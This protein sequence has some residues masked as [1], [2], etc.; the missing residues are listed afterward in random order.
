M[1][2][3]IISSKEREAL[4][5][6]FKGVD[7]FIEAHNN[8]SLEEMTTNTHTATQVERVHILLYMDF[9]KDFINDLNALRSILETSEEDFIK[10]VTDDGEMSLDTVEKKL[11]TSMLMKMIL[12]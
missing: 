4:E 2:N 7:E 12:K 8:N 1:K 10:T 9:V 6:I 5:K 3:T 11:M